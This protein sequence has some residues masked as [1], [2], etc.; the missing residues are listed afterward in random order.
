[1]VTPVNGDGGIDA[2]SA[3]K[4]VEHLVGN[5]CVPFIL[6]TT[7][8]AESL[9]GDQKIVLAGSVVRAA[10][11]RIPVLAGISSNS[12][13]TSVQLARHFAE[14]GV[15]AAVATLPSYYPMEEEQMF[16]YFDQL[17]S[18]IPIPLLL[19]NMPVTTGLS[20]PP[21]VIDRLSHHPNVA[22][23]KDSER[24]PDR[25]ERSLQLWSKREDFSFL[26]GWAD[27]SVYGLSKGADGIVPST[28]NLVP[29]L[30][31]Q[32]YRAA[33][34]GRKPEALKLQE[35]TERISM[36]YQGERK[37]NRSIPAL[38]VLLS[39]RDLCG[40]DVLP[41]LYRMEVEEERKYYAEMQAELE[42]MGV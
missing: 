28:A 8:E 15:E 14:I 33:L 11:G 23:L 3:R 21:G 19:Y 9:S 40:P 10:A 38:K 29:L 30:F 6:G 37:L 1:M 12:M 32:L 4:L 42:R 7:G 2:G 5:H 22:G 18:R 13:E 35:T 39:M 20:I 27:M 25:L 24:D 26:V 36:L 31:Q 16:R 17:A 41:P 34:D